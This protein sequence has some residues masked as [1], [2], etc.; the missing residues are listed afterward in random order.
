MKIS[1]MTRDLQIEYADSGHIDTRKMLA[2]SQD[3]HPEA[4]RVLASDSDESVRTL[5]AGNWATDPNTLVKML[6]DD[7][8]T[9]A[10]RAAAGNPRLPAYAFRQ[11]EEEGYGDEIALLILLENPNAPEDWVV[12]TREML[13][14]N[15]EYLHAQVD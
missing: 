13:N 15:Y 3:T 2:G 4:L 9:D 10:Q 6:L 12:D 5:V 11:R 8:Y 14:R 1:Q 7:F